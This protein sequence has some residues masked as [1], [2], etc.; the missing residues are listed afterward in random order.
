MNPETLAR[1][2]EEA[3]A[4]AGLTLIAL[5]LD[6]VPVLVGEPEGPHREIPAGHEGPP[7]EGL[8]LSGVQVEGYVL[9]RRQG[10]GWVLF[11]ADP[12]GVLH[13]CHVTHGL[14]Q[15]LAALGLRLVWDRLRD[16][17]A[18]LNPLEAMLPSPAEGDGFAY[19]PPNPIAQEPKRVPTPEEKAERKAKK[20]AAQ[21]GKGAAIIATPTVPVAKTTPGPKKPGGGPPP[22]KPKPPKPQP[23]PSAVLNALAARVRVREDAKA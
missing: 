1:V 8:V 3:A 4:L 19:L 16:R 5:P 2:V 20:A 17:M 23:S 12:E 15:V 7:P 14:R 13:R 10:G 21:A 6:R 22:P 9:T 18:D 11:R